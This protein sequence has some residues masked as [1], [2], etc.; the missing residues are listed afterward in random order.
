MKRN[1]RTRLS[2]LHRT[3]EVVTGRQLADNQGSAKYSDLF[4]D[5]QGLGR[6]EETPFGPCYLR[7][8]T[9]PLEYRHGSMALSGILSCSGNTLPLTVFNRDMISLDPEQCLFLDTETT[10][11]SGGAGTWAFLIGIGWLKG[12]NFILRQYFLRRPAEERAILSHFSATAEKFPT[13]VSF[14]GKLF[15]LPLIQTRQ[16]LAGFEQTAPLLHLD[17]LQYSRLFWKKRFPSRSL[18]ALEKGLLGIKRLDD[19]PGAEIPAVYFDFLRRGKTGQLKKVFRHNILDILSMVTLLERI[20]NLAAGRLIEHPAE[21]LAMGKLCLQSDLIE[22]GISHLRNAAAGRSPLAE[23]A[24]LELALYYKRQGKWPEAEEIWLESIA[25][26]TTNPGVYV[27]LAKY[28]EHRC[29][30][31]QS[32]LNLTRHALVLAAGNHDFPHSSEFST[33]ALKHRL[34]RLKRRGAN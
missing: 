2:D 29:S 3:G 14:N 24:A 33:T 9:Y 21:A 11:L 22:E 13:M 34:Q 15:D 16:T 32:A 23:E 6:V 19:I 31:Y 10:G 4:S 27:E 17:L 12:S 18:Q 25:K 5:L 28:Y 30:N 8:T 20:T 1:L 26:N 7:E